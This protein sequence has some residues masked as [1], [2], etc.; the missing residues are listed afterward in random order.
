MREENYTVKDIQKLYRLD[1]RLSRSTL[2]NAESRGEIPAA[3]RE[4]RGKTEVRMW[5]TDQLPQIGK[6][7][8]FLAGELLA[9]EVVSFFTQKG[10]TLKTTLAW[11]FG[12]ILALNGFR[13]LFIG[14]DVQASL[15]KTVLGDPDVKSLEELQRIKDETGGLFHLLFQSDVELEDVL[16][17]TDLP[18]LDIIPETGELGSLV[19]KLAE[20]PM[21]ASVFK[22]RLIPKISGYDFVIFDNAPTFST[23]V[24]NSLYASTTVISPIACDYGCYQVLDTNLEAVA[25]FQKSTDAEWRNYLFVPTLLEQTKLSQQIYESYLKNYAGQIIPYPLRR[26]VGGQE[27]SVLQKSIIEHNPTSLL[28]ADYYQLVN[29]IWQRLIDSQSKEFSGGN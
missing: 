3:R 29:S 28:A 20:D 21:R 5:S 25:K 22:K 27:A 10:G 12:R 7:F 24:E 17:K 4:T 15:T 16:K 6:K 11:T 14:L 8:G 19:F 1:E 13:V 26:S 9:P 18:T 23:L 2:L